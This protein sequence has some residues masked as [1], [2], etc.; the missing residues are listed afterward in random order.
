MSNSTVRRDPIVIHLTRKKNPEPMELLMID[1]MVTTF[2][3]DTIREHVRSRLKVMKD[4]E[5]EAFIWKRHQE[6][7]IE[8]MNEIE[9]LKE[10]RSHCKGIRDAH[11][12][13]DSYIEGVR[14]GFLEAYVGSLLELVESRTSAQESNPEMHWALCKHLKVSHGGETICGISKVP[15]YRYC[16]ACGTSCAWYNVNE[17]LIHQSVKI[18]DC[19][20]ISK[21]MA[22]D[23][24]CG[25][26]GRKVIQLSSEE[27]SRDCQGY[28]REPQPRGHS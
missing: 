23:Y 21:D 3:W 4:P 13:G 8:R 14:L 6:R 15:V 10:C 26:A 24:Y 11:E 19:R 18:C 2:A 5:V 17:T 20:F 25:K 7:M 1:A 16:R 27:C 28:E 9:L 12:K 22:G